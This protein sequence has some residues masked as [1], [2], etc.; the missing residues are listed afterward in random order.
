MVAATAYAVLLSLVV[1][2]S[3]VQRAP[4]LEVELVPVATGFVDPIDIGNDG[5]TDALY[6]AERSG[7]IWRLPSTGE[8]ELLLDL[9]ELVFSDDPQ[10]GLFS[11]AFHPDYPRDR[12][13][14][15]NVVDAD[16]QGLSV[17]E[18]RID[19]GADAG[20]APSRTLFDFPF[21]SFVH[22]GGEL[23]FGPDGMLYVPIG[24][25]FVDP[26]IG[27]PLSRSLESL[28][29]KVLR[30]DVDCWSTCEERGFVAPEDNPFVGVEGA[31]PEIWA[32]GLRN[33]YRAAFD[34]VTGSLLVG[35]VGSALFEEVNEVVAGGDYGW[36]HREG[37]AC[38]DSSLL[39]DLRCIVGTLRHRHIDPIASYQHLDR[40]SQG[41]NV[42]VGGAFYLGPASPLSGRYLFSDFQRGA[43]WSLERD[44]SEAT[45]WRHERLL[46]TGGLVSAFGNDLGGDV[47]LTVYNLGAIVKIVALP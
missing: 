10:S 30:L 25:G 32:Y 34:P 1:D 19:E 5:A 27:G 37:P 8:R 4:T 42:I 31:R 47:Y 41:G 21:T 36:N 43:L 35:D 11:F 24:D 20:A 46:E 6:V 12:R 7:A 13:V 3:S 16:D 29:G 40:D 14:Y 17:L 28:R 15:V 45:G 38:R 23:V 2:T 9:S 18:L 44:A 33:P 22:F 26:A 39:G